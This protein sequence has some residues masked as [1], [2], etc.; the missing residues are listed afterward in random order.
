[1][2]H[3]LDLPAPRLAAAIRDGKASAEAVVAESLRRARA[4]QGRLNPFVLLRDEQALAAARAI[5]RNRD[6]RRPLLGVPFA[7]K[8]LTPTKGDLTTLGSWTEGDHIAS[9]TALCI[10]RLEEAGAILIGKTT[11]PEF[12]FSSF[13]RSPRWGVTRNPWNPER[14][15]GGRR[16]DRAS[17]WRP[18][19]FP[20]PKAPT[21]AARSAFPPPAAAWSD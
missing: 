3:P 8:D 20:S 7:A 17:P 9:E 6:G 5:D 10:R 11:T 14:T 4:I 15:S 21:W 12:A 16:A 18:A 2:S 19:W 13:T 1:M